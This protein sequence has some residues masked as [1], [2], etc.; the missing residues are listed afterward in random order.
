MTD[1]FGWRTVDGP[2]IHGSRRIRNGSGSGPAFES[3]LT[4]ANERRNEASS[5]I[6]LTVNAMAGGRR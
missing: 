5:L 2:V 1:I 3:V 6:C 4:G